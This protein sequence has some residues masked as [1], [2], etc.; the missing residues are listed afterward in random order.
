MTLDQIARETGIPT[1]TFFGWTHRHEAVAEAYTRAREEQMHLRAD[2]ILR[3]ADDS[4]ND[5]MDMEI[6]AGRIVRQF[7]HEHIKRSE[8]RIKVRQW[9]MAKFSPRV[10]GER[11][12]LEDGREQLTAL[13]AKSADERLEDAMTLIARAR[14]RVQEAIESGE[15]SEAECEDVEE[16]R[17]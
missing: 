7:D 16:D 15:V 13:A 11:L 6:K 1:S 2:E 8:V 10:F 5:W 3:I 14:R 4:S 9:I 12:Q 17:S